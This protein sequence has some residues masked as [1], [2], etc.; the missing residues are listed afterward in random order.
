MT[1]LSLFFFFAVLIS[2]CASAPTH[3]HLLRSQSQPINASTMA[4]QTIYA[5][6]NLNFPGY[7]S[8]TAIV[9]WHDDNQL[10][11][12]PRHRWA[13]PLSENVRHILVQQVQDLSGNTAFYQYPLA[14]NIR[15][16]KILD[17]Q[18]SELIA[19]IAAKDFRLRASWQ[20]SIS[21]EHNPTTHT[22]SQHYPLSSHSIN[23]IIRA[24]QQA[25]FDLSQ[26]IA[27]TL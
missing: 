5:L 8:D 21:G 3:Y 25:L 27:H 4:K 20:V 13:E 11:I 19:D 17:V 1:R 6:R 12:E 7:L 10:I 26:A 9:Y 24:H 23:D 14:S 18:I 2:G 16:D 15:P 22:F